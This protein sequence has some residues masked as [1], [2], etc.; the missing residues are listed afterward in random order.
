ME[1]TRQ[2][3]RTNDRTLLVCSQP[4]GPARSPPKS[5]CRACSLH[6][7]ASTLKPCDPAQALLVLISCHNARTMTGLRNAK[8]LRSG[9]KSAVRRISPTYHSALQAR[10]RGNCGSISSWSQLLSAGQRERAEQCAEGRNHGSDEPRVFAILTTASSS[11]LSA[12]PLSLA[13]KRETETGRFSTSG[14]D[15]P[16]SADRRLHFDQKQNIFRPAV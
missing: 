14:Y 5:R 12:L 3:R 11:L 16:N 6:L 9:V 13:S 4:W 10:L 1:Q 7:H 2:T 8:G 15:Q